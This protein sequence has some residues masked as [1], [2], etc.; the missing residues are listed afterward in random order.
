MGDVGPLDVGGVA[1]DQR[2]LHI[3][4]AATP[5]GDHDAASGLG[6]FNAPDAIGCVMDDGAAGGAHLAD[7]AAGAPM[8]LSAAAGPDDLG[9]TPAG[10]SLPS[11]ALAEGAA[12][13]ALATLPKRS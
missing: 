2:P 11:A 4:A 13:L 7:K 9:S 10:V 3:S 6:Y 12:L 5:G 1:N 8:N